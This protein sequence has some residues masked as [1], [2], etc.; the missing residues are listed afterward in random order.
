VTAGL[1]LV[2]LA[3]DPGGAIDRAATEAALATLGVDAEAL[4]ATP[5][6]AK[7]HAEGDVWTHTQMALAA[8]VASDAYAAAD[9]IARG[10]IHAGVLFHDIGKPGTTRTELDGAITSRGHSSR[11]DRLARVAL[12]DAGVPF[13][14]REHVCALI[15][16]HQ[17]P[18]FAIDRSAADA[19][20]MVAR[21]SLVTRNDWLAAVAEADGRGRRCRDAADHRRIV[22]NVAL[23]RE[24]AAE[25]GA[26]DRPRAFADEHTRVMWLADPAG[27]A[28]EIAAFDDTTCEVTVMSG[29]PASGKD[30]WL[31]QLRPELPVVSLDDLRAT[32][33]IDPGEGQGAVVAAA[34]EAARVHLRERRSF[35]WNATTLSRELRATV[36]ELCRSYRARVHIVYCET[37]AAEQLRRNRARDDRA[38]VPA[39]ALRRMLERWSIPTPDEAHR[40]S[41]VV[42][43][44]AVDPGWPP[45][46]RR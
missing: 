23:Y 37:S 8:L 29:L 38:R 16:H 28:A 35:A 34:R 24:L 15:R 17:V 45:V 32:L 31:A 20:A 42:D 7:F 26:L 14:W 19:A 46:V 36:I 10:L 5:Q 40:V 25:S 13:A 12:W 44:I 39:T 18:F 30:E 43:G 21:M 4:A 41:Y 6:D 3:P 33:D 9:P 11:G 1:D 22:D 2:A 27:R